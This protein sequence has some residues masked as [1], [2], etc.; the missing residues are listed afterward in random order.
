MKIRDLQ[1]SLIFVF[2]LLV[3]FASVRLP[4]TF[5]CE[6]DLMS[7]VNDTVQDCVSN[8]RV[9]DGII[10]TGNGKLRRDDD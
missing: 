6:F 4:Y 8:R 3:P 5:T 1:E 7:G 10:P 9:S 2:A